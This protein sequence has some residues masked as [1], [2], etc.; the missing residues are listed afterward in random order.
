MAAWRH[1]GG[2]PSLAARVLYQR[3]TE[4]PSGGGVEEVKK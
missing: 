3:I 4:K 1:E 2:A